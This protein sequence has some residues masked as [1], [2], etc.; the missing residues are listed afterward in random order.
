MREQAENS[1]TVVLLTPRSSVSSR[2][3]QLPGILAGLHRYSTQGDHK[4]NVQAEHLIQAQEAAKDKIAGKE[5]HDGFMQWVKVRLGKPAGLFLRDQG[6]LDMQIS[7]ADGCT[8]T[9]C[10]IERNSCERRSLGLCLH[11]P[12]P[13]SQSSLASSLGKCFRTRAVAPGADGR[14]QLWVQRARG[15]ACGGCCVRTESKDALQL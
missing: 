11:K 6:G 15:T 2:G 4:T 3:K 10:R 12:C 8:K 5:S 13:G 1:M 9:T 7:L 14:G